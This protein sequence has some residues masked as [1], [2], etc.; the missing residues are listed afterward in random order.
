MKWTSINTLLSVAAG[1]TAVLSSPWTALLIVL[2]IAG[3]MG[4]AFY[5]TNK[6]RK[7]IEGNPPVVMPTP[8]EIDAALER[9]R[10][11]ID[12]SRDSGPIRLPLRLVNDDDRAKCEVLN[13]T[14]MDDPEPMVILRRRDSNDAP[15]HTV[16]CEECHVSETYP[17]GNDAAHS[18]HLNTHPERCKVVTA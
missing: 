11:V 8:Q 10:L 5:E 16:D 2:A 6:T 3:W 4:Q 9:L 12:A 15:P 18:A 1:L 7:R 17:H 13:V 14:L